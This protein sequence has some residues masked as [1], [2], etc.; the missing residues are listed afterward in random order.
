MTKKI[1]FYLIYFFLVAGAVWAQVNVTQDILPNTNTPDSTAILNN[2]LRQQQNAINTVGAYFNSNGYLSPANGGT[3]TNISAFPNGS[4]LIFDAGNVGIG[5]INPGIS[6]QYLQSQGA[7]VY[8]IFSSIPT[9]SVPKTLISTWSDNIGASCSNNT[10]NSNAVIIDSSTDWANKNITLI[11]NIEWEGTD[12]FSSG[13]PNIINTSAIALSGMNFGTSSQYGNR[14]IM[15]SLTLPTN[16]FT[17]LT[18]LTSTLKTAG[19]AIGTN[20]S[21]NLTLVST[22]VSG[23]G[24]GSFNVFSQLSGTIL[25]TP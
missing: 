19:I 5:T 10:T 21:G 22:C 6:G 7:G 9:Y 24:G 25:R 8:P 13:F 16:S 2:Q 3:G 17:Q 15:L 14:F 20:N 23:A 12:S 11:A 4:L 1:L 18:S